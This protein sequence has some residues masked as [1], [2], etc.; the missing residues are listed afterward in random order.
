M[1]M[2][3]EINYNQK[4]EKY[5]D[6]ISHYNIIDSYRYFQENYDNLLKNSSY[7]SIRT[8][9]QNTWINIINCNNIN[10]INSILHEDIN[11]YVDNKYIKGI[12]Y[13]FES[14]KIDNIIIKQY[15]HP[16]SF[17]QA[18]YQARLKIYNYIYKN[19]NNSK[20]IRLFGGEFYLFSQLFTSSLSIEAYTDCSNLYADAKY[21]N[22]LFNIS[23]IN[24]NTCNISYDQQYDI[25]IIQVSPNGLKPNLLKQI[26]K[27]NTKNIIL[28]GCK[29]HI[30][31]RDIM[32]LKKH[33]I[34]YKKM[35]DNIFMVNMCNIDYHNLSRIPHIGEKEIISIGGEC[36]VSHQLK[37]NGYRNN[38]YPFDWIKSSMDDVYK[39][40]VNSFNGF[41][42][43][44]NIQYKR[45]S[46]NFKFIEKDC[47]NN[48]ILIEEVKVGYIY[49]HTIFK[50]IEFC[51]DFIDEKK[52]NWSDVK[53][54]YERRIIRL[55]NIIDTYNCIFIR[56][57]STEI[58][59]DLL[60]LWTSN[61]QLSTI[62]ITNN[63]KNNKFMNNSY[64]VDD[65]EIAKYNNCIIIVRDLNQFN[66]WQRNNFLWKNLFNKINHLFY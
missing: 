27:L 49:Q 21:N 53:E 65:L 41:I 18:D 46:E 13:V 51:H 61:I 40:I 5:N 32:L 44:K 6:T 15:Q 26:Q 3:T 22:K 11:I 54:K 29:L 57:E 62:I 24:Y 8:N 43:E 48:T 12:E 56:Y 33:I 64:I 17:F 28:I 1:R 55:K 60:D 4:R 47:E 42:D 50:S 19:Y 45:K 2:R 39:L 16:Y 37:E 38:S 58:N 20:N 25:V 36:S 52:S 14:F 66:G 59:T 30:V 23:L 31:D 35:S 10:L 7:I 63:H 9:F 34:D